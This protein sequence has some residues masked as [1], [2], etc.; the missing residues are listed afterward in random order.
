MLDLLKHYV[1]HLGKPRWRHMLTYLSNLHEES[2]HVPF[3]DLPYLWEESSPGGPLGILFGGWDTVHIA[4]DNLP[5]D[6]QHAIH[7]ILNLLCLQQSDGMLP[8]TIKFVDNKFQRSTKSTFPPLWPMV[9]QDYIEKTKNLDNLP[10]LLEALEKQITWFEHN[11]KNVQGGFFYLDALDR[12]WESGVEDGVRY[13]NNEHLPECLTC[14]DATSHM[15]SLYL[16]AAAWSDLLGLQSSHWLEKAKDSMDL[17]QSELFDPETHF[18]HDQWVIGIP[19]QRRLSFEGF[20]PLVT[21]AAT[22]EQA[23]RVI[24]ENI[25][26]PNRLFTYHPI[27]TVGQHD[28]YFDYWA[29]RGPVRN[30]MTLWAAKGCLKYG[31]CDAALLLVERALDATEEQF[32][33]TGKIWEF[34]HPFGGDPQTLLRKKE[35]GSG[36]PIQDFLG[37]NPLI[38]MASLW[39]QLS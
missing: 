5:S 19:E 30:S 23:Q 39:E 11:R 33:K 31:R 1:K 24:D 7:Q 28:P 13:E 17:I 14:V 2:L 4:L 29:W 36:P 27:S 16:H 38:A 3:H 18:F 22:F 26:D 21:G 35:C 20:W 12:F 32:A 8:G 15:F 25:L 6:P 37:H 10:K 9:V 34:Y